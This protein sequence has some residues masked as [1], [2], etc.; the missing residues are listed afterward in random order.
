MQ[1]RDHSHSQGRLVVVGIGPGN[2]LDR[3]IR[4]ER[5]IKESDVVAGYHRYIELVQDLIVQQKIISS[6]MTQERQRC[7]RA[8]ESALEGKTVSLISS[9]DSGIYGMAGLALEMIREMD[10]DLKV[11]I[12]PGVSAAQAGA[13]AL[14]APLMLDFACV[15][16]SD[17]LVSWEE[18][19]SRLKAL[20]Q[21]DMVTVL[22][23]PKSKKRTWQIEKTVD[24]FLRSRPGSTLAGIVRNASLE[25]ES[26]VLTNLKDLAEQEMDMRSMVIIGN[27]RTTRIGSWLVTVRGYF[28]EKT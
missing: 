17:L 18:I 26:I 12:V 28:A 7:A 10:I 2:P 8:I 19:E 11:E 6:G 13:A 3:T 1:K 15:S 24:I 22:Y 27:S 9:G 25:Q 16:L 21:A 23:N 20:A 4:A 5:A 14:G